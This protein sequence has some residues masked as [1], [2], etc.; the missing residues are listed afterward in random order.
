M[1]EDVPDEEVQQ[2]GKTLPEG[3][4]TLLLMEDEYKT[5]HQKGGGITPYTTK[6]QPENGYEQTRH[7]TNKPE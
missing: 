4:N 6:S 1:I 7:T 3:A 5:T 2:I